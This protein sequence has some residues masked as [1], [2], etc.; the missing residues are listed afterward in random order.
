MDLNPPSSEPLDEPRAPVKD[1]SSSPKT[2]LLPLLLL[3]DGADTLVY[4]DPAPTTSGGSNYLGLGRII[5]HRVHSE[6]LLATGS[7]S[8][9]RL[10]LPR[11]Q[12]RVQKQHAIIFLTE[13]SC[14]LP[15]RTWALQQSK[16]ELPESCVGGE[17]ELEEMES[18]SISPAS[19]ILPD[20]EGGP[21]DEAPEGQGE[22]FHQVKWSGLPVEYSASRHREGIEHILHVLEGLNPKLDTPCKLWTFFAVAKILDVATVP[23]VS[24]HILSWFYESHNARFI[25]IHPEV[26]YRVACGIKASALC[27]DAFVG[28]VGDEALLYLIRTANLT[29]VIPRAEATWSRIQDFLDDTEVQ[30]IEYASKSF[31]DYVVSRFLNLAGAEMAWLAQI[32]EFGKLTQHLHD[33]PEDND[34]VLRLINTLK[35]R[36][37]QRIYAA[38]NDVRDTWRTENAIQSSGNACDPHYSNLKPMFDN[39]DIL[40]R[41]IGRRFWFRMTTSNLDAKIFTLV[42]P[43]H[44]SLAEVGS[45]LLAFRGQENAKIRRNVPCSEIDRRVH[46][47]NAYAILRANSNS[48]MRDAHLTSEN[49]LWNL[50]I[51]PRRPPPTSEVNRQALG[52]ESMENR[53]VGASPS[54]GASPLETF[55]SNQTTSSTSPTP[56]NIPEVTFNLT[57]FYI[58]AS[59]YINRQARKMVFPRERHSIHLDITDTLTGLTENEYRFLPLWA[60]GN[61]DGTGGVFTDHNIPAMETDGFSA[62]GPSFHTGSAAS[63]DD[64]FSDINPSDSQSTVQRA[65]HHAT[66]SHASDVVSVDSMDLNSDTSHDH[67]HYQNTF[68]HPR[69]TDVV[70]MSSGLSI[71]ENEEIDEQSDSASTAVIDSPT[72]LTDILDEVDMESMDDDFEEL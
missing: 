26:A 19:F 7:A 42:D 45:P 32:P 11:Y 59:W 58:D 38:L 43:N 6:K 20:N 41:V 70:S 31:A 35:D 25:E 27:R 4:I 51:N 66:L 12:T 72:E 39:R 52:S 62:P 67:P 56:S 57:A 34:M 60:G 29:T 21:E 63:N 9:Q 28:L 53:N 55:P 40:Q 17:D 1:M 69:G 2:T 10:F 65:S 18:T 3:M 68:E 46:D 54:F 13:V 44:N 15:I 48:N 22:K 23:A 30:R 24:D 49:R 5:P 8:F 61:D 47:F 16:W 64:S 36:I 37:R 71:D 50:T 33:Y 14:P